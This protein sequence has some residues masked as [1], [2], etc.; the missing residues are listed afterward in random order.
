[1]VPVSSPA[2][3]SSRAPAPVSPEKGERDTHT[4][5]VGGNQYLVETL[6]AREYLNIKDPALF[7]YQSF[8]SLH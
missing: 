2:Y 1:M 5:P 7:P 3:T 8:I 4:A 6:L